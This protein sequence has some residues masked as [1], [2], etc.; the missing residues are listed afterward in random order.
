MLSI[1]EC[2]IFDFMESPTNGKK[3]KTIE[4]K[5]CSKWKT[6]IIFITTRL[7]FFVCIFLLCIKAVLHSQLDSLPTTLLH[8][9][10]HFNS[11]HFS[12]TQA[13]YLIHSQN[14]SCNDKKY[15]ICVS[16]TEKNSVNRKKIKLFICYL[17]TNL[18]CSIS[19][20][21]EQQKKCFDQIERN[22]SV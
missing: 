21:E 22:T 12:L 9:F 5:C 11:K 3:I 17:L 20:I 1:P 10:F 14:I 19:K 6:L 13:Q 15:T 7:G 16:E 8:Y 2:K 18:D 4:V